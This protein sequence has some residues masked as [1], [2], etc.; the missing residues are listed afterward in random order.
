V[1][2]E[3]V[4]IS[5]GV[6]ALAVG[7]GLLAAL[8]SYLVTNISPGGMIAPGWLALAL[9]ENWRGLVSIAAATA[10]TYGVALLLNRYAI[11]YGKRLYATVMLV[12]LAISVG[13]YLAGSTW[14]PQWFGGDLVSYLVPGMVGYQL[15][16]QPV[17][18][19]LAA[20]AATTMGSCLLVLVAV[21]LP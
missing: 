8:G 19:T 1:T 10:A 21:S 7:F 11:L 16:R 2:P 12:G 20:I 14:L 17:L 13:A 4:E 5:S 18:P 15:V 3:I 6:G 9:V